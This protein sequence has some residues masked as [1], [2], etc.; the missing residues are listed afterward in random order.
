[1]SSVVELARRHTRLSPADI[2]HMH[3]LVG[4]W[5]LVADLCFADLLLFAPAESADGDHDGETFVALAQVRPTTG[6]TLYQSDWVGALTT[7]AE[8]PLVARSYATGEIIEGEIDLEVLGDRVRVMSIPVRHQG[9]VIGVVTRESTPKVSRFTGDL[10]RTYLAVFQRIARMLAAGEFPFADVDRAAEEVPRVGD[11]ALLVDA[12]GRVQFSSPNAISALHRIGVHGNLDGRQILGVAIHELVIRPALTARRPVTEE[13]DGGNETVLQVHC[14]PLLARGEVE[15]GLVL[16]RDISELK[17][18]DRLLM[19]K[20]ATIREIHHRVKNNLQT[21]SSLLRLQARR[22]SSDEARRAIDESVRRI[23]SIALV[24]ETLSREARDDIVFSEIARPLV[25]MVEE[26]MQSPDRRQVRVRLDAE[27]ITLPSAVA[28]VLAVV[29]NELLQNAMDHAYPAG[30][31]QGGTVDVRLT[32]EGETLIVL[33]TDDGVGLPEGFSIDRV[34][35]LGLSIVSTL[36][37]SE[38]NGHIELRPRGAVTAVGAGQRDTGAASNGE[39]TAERGTV[40]ELRI[41][42]TPADDED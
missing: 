17:R 6:Q 7:R 32:C 35:G 20:D 31:E 22:L 24:H 40:A 21:I 38:L 1:M 2:G 28:T 13:V 39:S 41:P 15:G 12:D 16:L 19:S 33:V 36:V 30:N 10:E 18:L 14:I 34:D 27:G 25:R 11:G 29:L 4:S 8:R 26:T 37:N 3:R 5:G 9:R 23:A 42:L